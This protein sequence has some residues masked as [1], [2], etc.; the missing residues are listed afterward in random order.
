MLNASPITAWEG[1]G[2]IFTYAGSLGALFWFWVAV[3]LCLTPLW[4]SLSDEAAA[5]REFG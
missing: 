1:A 3:L 4:V 2:A 5:E